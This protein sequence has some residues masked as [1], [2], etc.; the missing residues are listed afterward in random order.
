MISLVCLCGSTRFIEDFHAAN[1][2][3]T[4][5]GLSVITISMALPK[6][7]QGEET[8]VALK[9][10]LDLV[11]LHKIM[12]SDA[13]FVIGPGYFGESTARE[14]LWAELLGRPVICQ[15]DAPNWDERAILVK[16]GSD[17]AYVYGRARQRLG[18]TPN[19]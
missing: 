14:I 9:K 13:V 4:Q 1:V 8:E 19:Q 18:L 11:H 10:Y 16:A 7:Q 15:T 3:L 6:N 2:N 17:N 12:R 5:R